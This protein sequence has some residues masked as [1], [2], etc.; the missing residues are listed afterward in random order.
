MQ[1]LCMRFPILPAIGSLLR[2]KTLAA[3]DWPVAAGNKRDHGRLSAGRADYLVHRAAPAAC[4]A[5]APALR[6]PGGL[7]LEAVVNVKL[8][9][10]SGEHELLAA[11]FADQRLVLVRQ[12]DRAPLLGFELLVKSAYSSDARA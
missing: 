10:A 12:P 9:L 4:S 2:R 3:V 1:A 7:V 11:L 8:L 6:A 5:G